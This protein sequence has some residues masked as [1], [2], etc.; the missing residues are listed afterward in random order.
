M[1]RKKSKIIDTSIPRPKPAKTPSTI[2]LDEAGGVQGTSKTLGA[3]PL[4]RPPVPT[5][6]AFNGARPEIVKN[7]N[8]TTFSGDATTTI[9]NPL[10]AGLTS[11]ELEDDTPF[12]QNELFSDPA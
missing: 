4:Y 7:P 10:T 5:G 6:G 9:I 11:K 12:T 3:D 2:F 8:D 1:A